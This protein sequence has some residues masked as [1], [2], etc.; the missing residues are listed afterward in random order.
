LG[1]GFWVSLAV[2]IFVMFFGLGDTPLL[3]PDEPVYAQTPLEMLNSGDL[4][5]PRIY[6]NFWYDKP[7]MYYWLV[8]SAFAGIG[9]SEFASRLPSAIFGVLT[10][11]VV[12]FSASRHFG[13][14]AG[15]ISSLILA[16]S[17]EFFY[18]G[19]ASVTDMTL[20]F[21]LTVAL[22]SFLGERYWF[23]YLFSALAVLTKG[24][25]GILLP[26]AV[27]FL[28]I[29]FA[30]KWR[31]IGRMSIFPGAILFSVVAL[32][33]YLWMY[34]LHGQAFVDT[35]LG[36]HNLTRFTSPE[37]AAGAVWYYF[38]PV[39]LVGFFPWTP[40]LFQS[41]F[42]ALMTNRRERTLLLFLNIWAFVIFI[43]FSISA[44]KLV[45]YI[46]PMYPA[47]AILT[48]WYIDRY[49]DYGKDKPRAVWAFT[50]LILSS[51]LIFLLFKSLDLM[52]F[53][54]AGVL[55]LSSIIFLMTALTAVFVLYRKTVPALTVQVL[56]MCLFVM[57]VTLVLMPALSPYF[58]SQGIAAELKARY[59]GKTPVH[60][61]KFLQPGVAYY[62]QIF[63]DE[64]KTADIL[65]KRISGGASGFVVITKGE[66]EKVPPSVKTKLEE[67]TRSADRILFRIR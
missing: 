12:Y 66:Y 11:V 67:L 1:A 37:H 28:Y 27:V 32:P 57:S 10:V 60:V 22:L 14:R 2:A 3:D 6:G 15:T 26:G 64:F 9:P 5:S 55:A 21:C 40:I 20:T 58:T 51:G 25:V 44:T 63:G 49:W 53:L 33:W 19:K 56:A 39:L 46:L 47:I 48:G 41:V 52:P 13:Q 36:F 23:F 62:A 24:P 54:E 17:L 38:I 4:M 30:G 16:T 18:L 35:F 61:Q 65:A 43:F 34:R 50:L 7:P 29:L 42:S 31:E 45:S 59:D 8:A